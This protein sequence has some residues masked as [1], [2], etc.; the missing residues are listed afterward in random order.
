MKIAVLLFNLGGP[1]NL[2]AVRPFLFRLFNDPS[3]FLLPQP[4]R[5]VL[6]YLLAHY[7]SRKAQKI[8]KKAGGFS[9]L[10]K[11]TEE[12][13]RALE[14]EL[15]SLGDVRCFV[16]MRYAAPFIKESWEKIKKFD[17][18]IV[19]QLPLYPQYS[20]TTTGSSLKES[21]RQQ[22]TA[23]PVKTIESYP[24]LRGFIETQARA[25]RTAYSDASSFGNP[26]VLFSAHGLPEKIVRRGDPY[27]KQC[28]KTVRALIDA[29]GKPHVD[30]VLCY[31]SRVGPMKW[32]GPETKSE[33]INAGQTKRPIIVV[34]IS[35]V[36]EQ[37]ET[38]VEID[39]EYRT[40]ANKTGV[41]CFIRTPACGT[42]DVFIKGLAD[43]VREAFEGR[44]PDNAEEGGKALS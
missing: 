12:Q 19:V 14:K 41:P 33:I 2:R 31:Q 40:L 25:I 20:T 8:Y 13:A 35:F 5:C 18:D 26:V 16:G 23:I 3:I 24:D 7:R 15:K 44:K 9:P 28:E 34:P 17:P 43:L 11:N 22:H 42:A 38:L 36:S 21:K 27:P 6:A 29:L 30:T 4:F 39:Q 32:I 10:L 37:T 1:E